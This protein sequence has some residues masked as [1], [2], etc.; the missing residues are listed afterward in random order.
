MECIENNSKKAKDD[1][2][3]CWFPYC[4]KLFKNSDFLKKHVT[5]KHDFFASEVMLRN[6]EPYMRSRYEAEDIANRPLP[7]IEVEV[8]GGLEK[9]SIRDILT[10]YAPPAL[11]P[12]GPMLLPPAPSFGVPFQSRDS[13][14]ERDNFRDNRHDN[15]GVD[16]RHDI[17]GVDNRHGG[18]DNRRRFSANERPAPPLRGSVRGRDDRD[19]RR[20]TLPAG[21]LPDSSNIPIPVTDS[22]SP[23]ANTGGD[24]PITG[25]GAGTGMPKRKFSTYMDVD[26]PKVVALLQILHFLSLLV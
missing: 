20:H 14:R 2:V 16:N 1:K 9:R 15:R 26:A 11:M 17:R 3:R 10:K 19:M 18:N 5:L 7:P 12:P 21:G 22:V 6:A 24:T 13:H 25:P 4:N 23:N 8:P